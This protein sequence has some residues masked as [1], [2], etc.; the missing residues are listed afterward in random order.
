MIEPT[1]YYSHSHNM[2]RLIHR[3]EQRCRDGS[4][5]DAQRCAAALKLTPAPDYWNGD[6]GEFKP[7]TPANPRQAAEAAAF[8][9]THTSNQPASTGAQTPL[10]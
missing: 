3:A 4:F 9:L 6:A 8:T 7:L 5:E 10:F 1:T 2:W